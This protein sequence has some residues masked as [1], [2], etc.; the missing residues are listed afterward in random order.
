MSSSLQGVWCNKRGSD[1]VTNVRGE[2]VDDVD[3]ATDILLEGVKGYEK[4]KNN[5]MNYTIP[6]GEFYIY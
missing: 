3:I 5:G 2:R 1:F 6:V 4:D